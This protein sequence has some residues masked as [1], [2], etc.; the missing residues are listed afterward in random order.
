MKYIKFNFNRGVSEYLQ[1]DKS[2]DIKKLTSIFRRMKELF[3]KY[4][5]DNPNTFKGICAF[6]PRKVVKTSCFHTFIQPLVDVNEIEM[7]Q[8]YCYIYPLSKEYVQK[9]IDILTQIIISLR[10]FK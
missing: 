6:Y 8:T 2:M 4:H 1:Y 7:Y 5:K 3:I 9:R 10:Q